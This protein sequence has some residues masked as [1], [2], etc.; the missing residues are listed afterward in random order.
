MDLS[1][2]DKKKIRKSFGKLE[3]ILN[4]PDLIEVQRQSY[5]SFLEVNQ[6]GKSGLDKVFKEVYPIEDFAGLA[7]IE[8]VDYRFEN[9]KYDVGECKQRGLT[10]SAPLKATLRL[11]AYDVNEENQTKQILSA[12]E[13]EVYM[14]DIPLMTPRGT[15]VVN[16]TERVVVNQMHRSPGLFLDDDKGKG[17]ASGKKLFNCRVIPYRGSWLDFEFDIKDNLYFR[18]DRK[19]IIPATTLLM[20]SLIHI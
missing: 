10:Y 20:L 7:T 11:V 13:Q 18:I 6:K 8:Y 19:R 12:K 3:N 5:N 2:T 14:G 17:H 1:F 9:P 4:I 16:G 15:F